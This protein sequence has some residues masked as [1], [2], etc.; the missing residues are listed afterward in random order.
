MRASLLVSGALATLLGCSSSPETVPPGTGGS[1]GG[2]AS[3]SVASGSGGTGGAPMD[4]AD[5]QAP[6]CALAPDVVAIAIT[7]TLG[8]P[9]AKG[10]VLRIT[11]TVHNPGK[12]GGSAQL[13]PLLDSK[14][15]T[16]FTA[17]PL[18]AMMVNLAPG[19]QKDV[20]LDAGP[21]L[22]D[23]AQNK[24]FAV[25]RGAYALSGVRVLSAG[26]AEVLDQEYGGKDFTIAASNVVFNAVV[27]DQAFLDHQPYQGTA[28]EFMIETHTRRSELFTPDAPGSSTGTYVKHPGGFDEMMGVHHLYRTFPAFAASDQKGGFCEQAGAYAHT[29]LG[30]TRDWDIKGV[31]TNPDHHGFDILSGLTPNLGGGATCG[32]LGTEVIGLFDFDLSL[33]RSEIIAVHE[34]GHIFGAPHCDPLQG[35]VMCSGEK[36]PHYQADG[37]FVWHQVSRDA[38]KNSYD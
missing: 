14:R 35:Y 5:A 7:N 33:N 30:L 16:D 3:S 20:T 9:P 15:F 8:K 32:W 10:D 27:F 34:T 13:T 36:H 2:A 1:G 29:V 4:C 11:L 26:A 17:V 31:P 12:L 18:G 19:E 21:F 6:G 37:T 38:M 25:G 23:A 24:H 28:E 22:D